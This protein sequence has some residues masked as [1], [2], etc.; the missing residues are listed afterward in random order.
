MMMA[1]GNMLEF[2]KT[3]FNQ[4]DKSGIS[5]AFVPKYGKHLAFGYTADIYL[6]GDQVIKVFSRDFEKDLVFREAFC[7]ACVE[8]TGINI[9]QILEIRQE[10][11]FWVVVSEYISGE[12]Q[13]K[14]ICAASMAGDVKKAQDI[15]RRITA[16][17]AEINQKVSPCLPDYREYVRT[18]ITGNPHL[19][20]VCREKTLQY[21][22]TLPRG[23][24]IVHGD[25]HPQNV[26]LREDGKMYVIDWVEAGSAALGADAARSYMNYL[27]MPPVPPLMNPE[28]KLAE[29]YL[30]TYMQETGVSKEE[31]EAWLPV[32]A[33]I[34]YGEKADWYNT[35]IKRFL[36]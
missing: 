4:K 8:R 26:L 5:E 21:L 35:G 7:M 9:P 15:L 16:Y 33:A 10:N 31:I 27:F 34:S 32:H 19:S 11:G 12:D 29:V 1:V 13:L 36:L 3:D 2:K 6:N 17:Q 22:D 28:L 25:F 24:G 30:E 14:A 18:I 20:E 23:S